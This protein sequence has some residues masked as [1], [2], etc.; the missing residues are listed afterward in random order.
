MG[1]FGPSI[2]DHYDGAIRAMAD[3]VMNSIA[4][5]RILYDRERLTTHLVHK[6]AFS[7]IKPTGLD[8][9]TPNDNGT[10]I[11]IRIGVEKHT[12]VPK[13]LGLEGQSV[14][15]APY[16]LGYND[17]YI[18]YRLTHFNAEQAKEEVKRISNRI[19]EQE[20]HPRNEAVRLGNERFMR[21][22]NATLDEKTR[23]LKAGEE[24]RSALEEQLKDL[25]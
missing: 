6:Y 4:K 9:A 8:R 11:L 10:E 24:R 23:Q 18:E 21:E 17:G 2:S 3:E 16:D 15:S 25:K 12:D 19:I 14:S 7:E 20:I 1:L 5:E 22:L 13:L